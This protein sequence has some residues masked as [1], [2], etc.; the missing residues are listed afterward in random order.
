MNFTNFFHAVDDMANFSIFPNDSL[1]KLKVLFF[2]HTTTG[3]TYLFFFFL[4]S[5][6]QLTNF[7]I[8]SHDR[9]TNFV[10]FFH[11]IGNTEFLDLSQQLIGETQR[12]FI[13]V[14]PLD[15][16]YFFFFHT[17]DWQ[18]SLYFYVT[19]WLNL[20]VFPPAIDW[21]NL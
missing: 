14:Q 8:F 16:F 18:I 20:P 17:T 3:Q 7:M 9:S 11:T 6:N 21:Q 19:E 5:H 12:V 4:L 1:E 13:F 15:E 10:I 2:S